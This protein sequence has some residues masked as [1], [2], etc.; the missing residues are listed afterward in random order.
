MKTLLD[1]YIDSRT[2]LVASVLEKVIMVIIYHF[3]TK[4]IDF[5]LNLNTFFFQV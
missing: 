2:V 5:I 1:Y 4:I 3:D